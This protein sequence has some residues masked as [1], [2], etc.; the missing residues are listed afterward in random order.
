M[1]GKMFIN[2]DKYRKTLLWGG[3]I[4]SFLKIFGDLLLYYISIN[5]P[6]KIFIWKSFSY[7]SVL[8]LFVLYF[9]SDNKFE[10][11]STK[12]DQNILYIND[13]LKVSGFVILIS[14]GNA[15]YGFLPKFFDLPSGNVSIF[16]SE[17]LLLVNLIAAIWVIKFMYKWLMA[18]RN[19]RTLL[20]LKMLAGII[21]FVLSHFIITQFNPLNNVAPYPWYNKTILFAGFIIILILPGK[22]N[23]LALVQ[24]INKYKIVG[25]SLL[26]SIISIS[27]FFDVVFGDSQ[28]TRVMS[29]DS[30]RFATTRNEIFFLPELA[31]VLF[32][33]YIGRIFI[34]TLVSLPTTDVLERQNTEISS[35]A[36]LNR[37]ISRVFTQ[38]IS[39]L[40]NT[41]NRLTIDATNATIAWTELYENDEINAY[42][43]NISSDI[44]DVAH[45]QMNMKELFNQFHKPE[46]FETLNDNNYLK[47]LKEY[48]YGVN[49]LI[50]APL[51]RENK[52]TGTLVL[53]SNEEYGFDHDDI[54]LVYAFCDNINIALENRRLLNDSIEKEKYRNELIL[55]RKIQ[56]DLLPQ[57]LPQIKNYSISAYS[58]P[59]SEVGGDYYD[60]VKLKDG[61][62]CLV[63]ADVSGKGIS[64]AFYMAKLQGVVLSQAQESNSPSELLSRI[65]KTLFGVMDRR[66]YITMSCLSIDDHKGRV[67]FS[68][69]GHMPLLIKSRNSST[70]HAPTGLGIG[71]TD[72]SFFSKRIKQI[73]IN[74]EPGDVSIL[75]TDG[76]NELR[77]A[78]NEEFGYENIKKLL[79]DKDCKKAINYK[80]HFIDNLERFYGSNS[81]HDDMTFV[82]LMYHGNGNGTAIDTNNNYVE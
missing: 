53:A 17:L 30:V 49:S 72:D 28:A 24:K 64:A 73:S 4:F 59:A 66:I 31:M 6:Y 33:G 44:I 81:I 13:L 5:D 63:I 61:R 75:F 71:L 38:N 70:M 29:Y 57:K 54:K 74:L 11:H 58:I 25:L 56:K 8:S 14:I 16:A 12:E 41:V 80:E 9:F 19:R 82:I 77:N 37:Y 1:G 51:Y 79:D 3:I 35:L 46:Y 62:H 42:S 21:A 76:I 32:F 47:S 7:F 69:A 2:F 23:W 60:I 78:E 22:N 52:R 36:N 10:N 39:D 68:R 18:R 40:F 43:V 65:N 26:M 34:S 55:G 45:K 27:F 20:L 48:L 67:T 15:V 50:I